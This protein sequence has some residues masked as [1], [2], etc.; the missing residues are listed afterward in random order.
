MKAGTKKKLSRAFFNMDVFTPRGFY[1][2]GLA[3]L[4]VYLLLDVMGL[5][6]YAMLLSGTSPAGDP[7]S[8]IT[9]L[10]AVL[11]ILFYLGAAILTPILLLASAILRVLLRFF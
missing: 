6:K 5:R 3:I 10:L 1:I 9:N 8:I 2:R 4:L 7:Q 11:Y